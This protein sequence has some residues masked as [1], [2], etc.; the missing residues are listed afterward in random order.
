MPFLELLIQSQ[1]GARM[2]DD[3]IREEVDTIM[4]AVRIV[5]LLT[6]LKKY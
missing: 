5:N 4:F 6:Y 3:D 2:S 1:D